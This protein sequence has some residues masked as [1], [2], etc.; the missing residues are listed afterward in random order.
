MLSGRVKAEGHGA[1]S[2]CTYLQADRQTDR[3]RSQKDRR[4]VDDRQMDRQTDRQP[5]DGCLSRQADT[6]KNF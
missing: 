5:E 4:Q 3:H 1:G 2:E 6:L